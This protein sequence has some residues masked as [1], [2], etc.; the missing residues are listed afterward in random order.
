MYTQIIVSYDISNTKK[1][2][3]FF[4]ELKD[5]GLIPIQK[6]LF[7]GYVLA[8]EKVII[9]HLFKI[10][11]D[12]KTYKAIIVNASLDKDLKN[13]FGYEEDDFKHPNSFE[14]I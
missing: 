14:I 10:Y 12:I 8:S 6:S 3:K 13:S 11:C 1:R 4:E 7:W 5:I 9:K 2:T